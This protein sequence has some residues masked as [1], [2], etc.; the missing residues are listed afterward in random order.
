MA[1]FDLI[2]IGDASLDV[3]ITPTESE[4]LCQL[5][6]KEAL[7]CFSYGEKIPVKEMESSIGGNAANNA[8]GTKRL[9]VNSAV[10][11]TLGD[12]EVGARLLENLKKKML[13]LHMYLNKLMRN[14]ITQQLLIILERGRY[15][16]IKPQGV[17]SIL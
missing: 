15:F 14:Q 17:M 11:I 8:V 2:T 3:F 5:D 13:I 7:V 12:D 4:T 10:M 9:G 6:S 1:K 16:P